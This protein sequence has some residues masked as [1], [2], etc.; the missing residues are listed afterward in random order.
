M[1]WTLWTLWRQFSL[2][3][4]SSLPLISLGLTHTI[5]V[6]YRMCTQRFRKSMRMFVMFPSSRHRQRRRRH[7]PFQQSVMRLTCR[8]PRLHVYLCRYKCTKNIIRCERLCSCLFSIPAI[9]NGDNGSTE[10]YMQ[11]LEKR[12]EETI[13]VK[14]RAS[15]IN[16]TV[17]TQKLIF[18]SQSQRI[19]E[20]LF[21]NSNQID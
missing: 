6:E 5:R 10:K 2:S 16:T 18:T 15:N 14:R 1:E 4:V 3:C 8:T 13:R 7:L 21:Q 17:Q 11:I 19:I 20:N 12:P 9:H